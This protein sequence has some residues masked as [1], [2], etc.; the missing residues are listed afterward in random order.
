MHEVKEV[1]V[2]VCRSGL[3]VPIAYSLLGGG[4]QN[5]EQRLL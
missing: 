5:P 1:C 3:C 2:S 4:V